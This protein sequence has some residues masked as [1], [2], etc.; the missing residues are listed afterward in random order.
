MMIIPEGGPRKPR[1]DEPC[2]GCGLCCVAIPCALALDYV[3]GAD[4]GK[5]CPAL[6]W[7]GGRS[8]CGLVRNPAGHSPLLALASIVHGPG[9][10]SAEI[11]DALGGVGGGC[12]SG[13]DDGSHDWR[14]G[15]TA[16]DFHRRRSW[17][18]D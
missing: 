6:E 13:P 7:E 3:E 9:A 5:P 14:T 10:V 1:Y 15:L 2:N 17:G 18:Q 12:D 8:F 16:A 4:I 11:A